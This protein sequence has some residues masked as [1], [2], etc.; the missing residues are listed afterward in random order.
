MEKERR[1]EIFK[2]KFKEF[3]GLPPG[4]KTSL[5]ETAPIDSDAP[6]EGGLT[7]PEADG[8][9]PHGGTGLQAEG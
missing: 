6:P 5:N 7:S 2:A 1:S 3:V 4:D 8:L 9:N